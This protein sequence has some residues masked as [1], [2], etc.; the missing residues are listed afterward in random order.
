MASKVNKEDFRAGVLCGLH[1][2]L[3]MIEKDNKAAQR[4]LHRMV[5]AEEAHE[6][7]YEIQV[8]RG[9]LDTR[10]HLEW[11]LERLQ[12]LPVDALFARE[13]GMAFGV[14]EDRQDALEDSEAVT[15]T[16]SGG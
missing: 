9:M 13:A 5:S 14:L 2:G 10:E 8:W 6:L 7:A 11:L 12:N 15:P 1:E 4:E 3:R 16:A